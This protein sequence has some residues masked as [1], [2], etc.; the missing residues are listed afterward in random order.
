MGLVHPIHI[1][2]R[3]NGRRRS[4]ACIE[5]PGAEPGQSMISFVSRVLSLLEKNPR[6]VALDLAYG[7]IHISDAEWE[8]NV[9]AEYSAAK[10]ERVPLPTRWRHVQTRLLN[11][12]ICK[13]EEECVEAEAPQFPFIQ[14]CLYLGASTEGWWSP[15]V[16]KLHTRR[17]NAPPD[18]GGKY[19]W[20]PGCTIIDLTDRSSYCMVLPA[21]KSCGRA[22]KAVYRTLRLRPLDG[23]DWLRGSGQGSKHH[24]KRDC[25]YIVGE[26]KPAPV[27]SID[28]IR[29]VW[30]KFPPSP[31]SVDSEES[32]DDNDGDDDDEDSDDSGD[33]TDATDYDGVAETKKKNHKEAEERASM[34]KTEAKTEGSPEV[35]EL[36]TST[37][38]KR[39][40][41]ADPDEEEQLVWD[42]IENL[43]VSYS[44]QTLGNL[45]R[46]HKKYRPLLKRF[47]DQHPEHF[48][49]KHPG[50]VPL[51]LAAF[52]CAKTSIKDLDLHRLRDLSGKQVV[53]LVKG[54]LAHNAAVYKRAP[55]DLE[56]LDIS[57]N[58]LVG[59]G[60]IVDIVA[61]TTLH[62][63]IIWHNPRLSREAVAQASKGRIAKVTTRADFLKPLKKFAEENYLSKKSLRPYKPAPPIISPL[64]VKIR[65]VIWMMIGSTEV[66]SSAPRPDLTGQLPIPKGKLSLEVVDLDTLSVL[67]HPEC[68]RT[69][70]EL[71]E[72]TDRNKAHAQLV[73]LPYHDAAWGSLAEFYTAIARFET[74]MS[75]K[76]FINY[77]YDNMLQ[78][79]TVAFPLHMATGSEHSEY[80]VT[81]PL[82]PESFSLATRELMGGKSSELNSLPM[83][84]P[85]PIVHEE[86]TLVFLREPDHGRLRIGMATLTE[87]GKLI[88]LDPEDVALEAS[89]EK[90]AL[91][92]RRGVGRLP[93][94]TDAT[95]DEEE[96]NPV[97][98]EKAQDESGDLPSKGRYNRH[99]AQLEVKA[100]ETM[101]A[102]AALLRENRRMIQEKIWAV[103]QARN[104]KEEEEEEEEE[105]PEEVKR[106]IE[107]TEDDPQ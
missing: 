66:D 62:E 56:V 40:R 106:K 80:V 82:P 39:K 75:N 17:W 7:K 79:W 87:E 10:A 89:D 54:A 37:S 9:D 58:P 53:E 3:V 16:R 57:F 104:K 46:Q 99:T 45:K 92:W 42:I 11:E 18:W 86:Y 35:P 94:W 5:I 95:E 28:A 50:A 76:E 96:K 64:P 22:K 1:I 68:H 25:A 8:R 33:D 102:G 29:E 34:L 93:R 69:I 44:P 72:Y 51:I 59:E 41:N 14:T 81:A 13:L 65:Q 21:H 32:D 4:I 60:D 105:E 26:D 78:R 98:E 107:D 49:P 84:G 30:P 90:A 43:L 52:K 63:L 23:H 27:T 97:V 24:P 73:A 48:A 88:V 6:Y 20:E 70:G 12:K 31:P 83:R 36:E 38:R 71:Y 15:F 67:L 55:K 61:E 2:A 91:A 19:M 85:Y 100:L 74:F 103:K 101:L 47:I 77:G